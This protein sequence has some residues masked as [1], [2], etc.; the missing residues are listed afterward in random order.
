[1]NWTRLLLD[2]RSVGVST[3]DLAFVGVFIAVALLIGFGGRRLSRVA[4]SRLLLLLALLMAAFIALYQYVDVG[5][6]PE[7]AA[8]HATAM[9]FAQLGVYVLAFK[10]WLA[11]NYG[12]MSRHGR[13][14]LHL[15]SHSAFAVA[16][17]AGYWL[18]LQHPAVALLIYP[19]NSLSVSLIAQAIETGIHERDRNTG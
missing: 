15:L 14:W 19:L 17:F 4:Y 8:V 7:N 13:L 9:A 5:P 12:E 18:K 2:P 16:I 11:I 6:E 1:M 3:L 10:L